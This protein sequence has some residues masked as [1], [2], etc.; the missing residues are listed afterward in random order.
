MLCVFCKQ[1]FKTKRKNKI[2]QYCSHECYSKASGQ[3]THPQHTSLWVSVSCKQCGK[4][5]KARADKITQ[6]TGGKFCSKLCFN[7]SKKG[8]IP[9]HLFPFPVGDKHP[10]WVEP[11]KRICKTCNKAFYVK[12]GR[13]KSGKCLF[14]SVRCWAIYRD[15]H[16]P[17]KD[18]SIE[19]AVANWLRDIGVS[20][21]QQILVC[22]IARVD[23]LLPNNL[24]IEADG[25]YWHGRPGCKE[26]D[27]NRDFL[28]AWYGYKTIRL[29]ECEIKKSPDY[30]IQLIATEL[31]SL[32]TNGKKIE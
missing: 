23:F 3:R 28:L 11:I 18:T 1:P 13:I 21:E 2:P 7:N 20:F 16:S 22:G 6:G 30:C 19:N 29:K 12:P 24:I 31:E 17:R 10:F 5:F 14:C 27:F 25:D 9:K 32:K 15:L 4:I 26:R 8:H